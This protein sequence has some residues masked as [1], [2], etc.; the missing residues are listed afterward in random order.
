M[1]TLLASEGDAQHS[2]WPATEVA[3]KCHIKFSEFLTAMQ[4]VIKI[5]LPHLLLLLLCLW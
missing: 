5:L 1:F 3:V 4:P 2:D